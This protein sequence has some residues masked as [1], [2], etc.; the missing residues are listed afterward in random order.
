ME[1]KKAGNLKGSYLCWSHPTTQLSDWFAWCV[2]RDD[3]NVLGNAYVTLD[4]LC[5]IS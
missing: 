5:L 2:V 4:S 3:S 1:F